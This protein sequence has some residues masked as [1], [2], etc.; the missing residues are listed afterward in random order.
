MWLILLQLRIS[1]TH[2]DLEGGLS[3]LLA[4]MEEAE[5]AVI[6]LYD[7]AADPTIRKHASDYCDS[8]REQA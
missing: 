1:E 6:C 7:Q 8:L 2:S 4:P 5:K 3:P